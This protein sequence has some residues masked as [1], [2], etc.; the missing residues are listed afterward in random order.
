[1]TKLKMLGISAAMLITAA[2]VAEAK[3]NMVFVIDS[4]GSMWGQVDGVTKM[5]TARK[6]LSSLIGDLPAS[7]NIGLVAY[8]HRDKNSCTDVQLIAPIAPR[9]RAVATAALDRLSPLGKTPIAYALSQTGKL[10]Q[11]SDRDDTNHVVLISDGIETCDGDPCAMAA[12]LAKQNVNTKV[13]VVGF[14]IAAKDRAQLQCIAEKGGGNYFSADSTAG[15]STAVKAVVKVA[16]QPKPAPAPEP[17]PEPKPAPKADLFFDDFKGNKLGPHWSVQ[18]PDADSYTVENGELLAIASG[19]ARL[20]QANVVNIFKLNT[21]LPSGDWVATIKFRMPYQTGRETPFFGLYDNKDNHLVAMANAHSYY[22]GTRGSRLYLS[23]QKLL[24]AKKTGFNKVI[25]GGASGK[26]FKMTELPN[27]FVLRI[28]KKG[29][30]YYPAVRLN[31][32]GETVWIEQDK[33]TM[34]RAKG[35]LAFGIFQSSKVAGETPMY[36]DYVKVQRP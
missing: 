11:N 19:G 33:I 16:A 24:K 28:T 17:K 23:S 5:T 36:V 30:S 26:P 15:F 27:P 21:K 18:N 35:N 4:S 13:H 12:S 22:G 31:K 10:F 7:T 6:V 34:L 29:R 8:G 9:S 25:W 32:G 3:N 20:E 14:D 1:M 2:T